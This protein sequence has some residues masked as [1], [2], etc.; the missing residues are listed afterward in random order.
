MNFG[1]RITL[2]RDCWKLVSGRERE[3][4]RERGGLGEERR[5]R[6]ERRESHR[7]ILH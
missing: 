2:E 1:L 4:E 6:R 3:R 5:E 7:V